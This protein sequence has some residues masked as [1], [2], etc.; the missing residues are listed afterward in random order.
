MTLS[1]A[2]YSSAIVQHFYDLAQSSFAGKERIVD[3]YCLYIIEDEERSG[4]VEV[5]PL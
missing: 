5:R 1:L 4:D 3:T 2:Y